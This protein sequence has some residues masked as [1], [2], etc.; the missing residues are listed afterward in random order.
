MT[1]GRVASG[2][3]LLLL[4]AVAAA[5]GWMWRQGPRALTITAGRLPEELVYARSTDDVVNGGVLFTSPTGSPAKVA[6]IWV[7]GWGVNFYAPN[8]RTSAVRWPPAG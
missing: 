8:T 6:A 3:A 1:R 4:V 2:M 7:H 5:G